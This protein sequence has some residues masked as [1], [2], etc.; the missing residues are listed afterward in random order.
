MKLIKIL[1]VVF[2][3]L[4][5]LSC[6]EEKRSVDVSSILID[7]KID[8]FEQDY[9]NANPETFKKIKEKYHAFFPGEQTDSAWLS[10]AKDSL[11]LAL[12]QEIKLKFGDFKNEEEQLKEVFK[13]I[14]YY[15]PTFKTPRIVTLISKLDFEYQVLYNDST[16]VLSLDTFLGSDNKFY[17][18]LPEYIRGSFDEEQLHIQ[19]ARLFAKETQPRIPHRV[20][21]ERSIAVGQLQYAVTQFIPNISEKDLFRYS[22]KKTKWLHENEEEIWKYFIEKEYLYN[23]DKDLA[24]RFLDPAPFTKFYMVFD[25][26]SPGRVGEWMG[27]RIVQSYMK[28]NDVSL[29][30]MMA[31]PPSEIF[32]KSKYKP[33]R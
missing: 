5:L 19:V 27:Y 32:K 7:L 22:D 31:T 30:E 13:H 26:E 12:F 3:F 15:Y 28:N 21:I 9:H 25:N 18:N 2:L 1:T 10:Y 8:R 14:K 4:I 23:T 24:R 11:W 33:N 29:P 17:S 16:L 6:E 20:F